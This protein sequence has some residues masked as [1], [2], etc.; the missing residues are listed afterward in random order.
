MTAQTNPTWDS[1]EVITKSRY[2]VPRSV[3]E[4]RCGEDDGTAVWA[5][6]ARQFVDGLIEAGTISR[7]A[8]DSELQID[9]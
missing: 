1:V 3:I 4:E 5:Y 2:A 6:E 7:Y 8:V 9:L